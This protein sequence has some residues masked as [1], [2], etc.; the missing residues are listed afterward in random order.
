MKNKVLTNWILKISGEEF[1]S[2]I[3]SLLVILVAV[4]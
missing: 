4:I 1:E 3:F 2:D